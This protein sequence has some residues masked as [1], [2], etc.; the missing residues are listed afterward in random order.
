MGVSRE[1][2]D[3]TKPLLF[4]DEAWHNQHNVVVVA[5]QSADQWAVL[6]GYLQ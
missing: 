1:V 5:G 3:K 2:R 6:E 4:G